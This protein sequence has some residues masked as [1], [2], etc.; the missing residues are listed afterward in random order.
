MLRSLWT[1]RTRYANT[2]KCKCMFMYA[3][4]ERDC[5]KGLS[6]PDI[7]A[8]ECGKGGGDAWRESDLESLH[9]LA[10][11]LNKDTPCCC[12]LRTSILVSAHAYH[13]VK[14]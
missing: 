11:V 13:T 10:L 6:C 9:V 5:A 4:T 3:R 2:F 8:R 14:Y 1:T 7:G 12:S